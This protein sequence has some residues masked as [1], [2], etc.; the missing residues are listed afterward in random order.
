MIKKV[1]IAICVFFSFLVFSSQT[2]FAKCN[3]TR[4]V[5]VPILLSATA[6]DSAVTLEWKEGEGPI[7]HYLLAYGMSKQNL[8]YGIQNIGPQ[9]TTQFTIQQLTN[10]VKYYFRVRP[11]NGCKEGKFSNTITAVSGY[12]SP[13][14]YVPNLSIYKSVASPSSAAEKEIKKPQQT[15]L[16]A[17]TKTCASCFGLPLLIAEL[18]VLIT[19][20]I[21]SGRVHSSFKKF[22]LFIP[23]GFIFAFLA[24]EKFCASHDFFCEYFIPLSIL[25]FIGVTI[26]YRNIFVHKRPESFQEKHSQ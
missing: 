13:T 17:Q 7:S 10:G 9:G 26:V 15:V 5:G 25:I 1:F 21:V 23:L 24:Q 19:A 12:N 14:V 16:A 18:L 4:P 22:S 11:M 2:S 20:L 8:E 3:Q 6:S